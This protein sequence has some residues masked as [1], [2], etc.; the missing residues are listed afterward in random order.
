MVF[1]CLF[2]CSG[3]VR[4]G[5]PFVVVLFDG[6]LHFPLFVAFSFELLSLGALV[7]S[8]F[9][10]GG[11]R[12]ENPSLDDVAQEFVRAGRWERTLEDNTHI[13]LQRL[14]DAFDGKPMVVSPRPAGG[15]QREVVEH[16]SVTLGRQVAL[17]RRDLQW[18]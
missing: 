4:D 11:L 16:V 2:V 9:V 15:T 3:F 17:S 5:F 10:R 12:T 18:S 6:S 14:D 13:A 8:C 7:C 1:C